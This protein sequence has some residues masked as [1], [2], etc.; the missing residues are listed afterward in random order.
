MIAIKNIK[1]GKASCPDEVHLERLK[2]GNQENLFML[3]KLSN[4]IYKTERISQDWLKS[5]FVLFQKITTLTFQVN[6]HKK[7]SPKATA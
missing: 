3:T 1:P 7:P 5:V 2:L 6:K 4:E